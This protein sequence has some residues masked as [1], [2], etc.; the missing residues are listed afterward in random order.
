MFNGKEYIYEIY[1]A[2]SFS[3]AAK[4]LFIS[5]PALSAAVRKIENNLG[6]KIFNRST[7]PITLTETGKAYITAVKQIMAI[8]QNFKDQIDNI[9]NLET[10]YLNVGGANFFSSCMLPP[11]I[12][13]FK[14]SYQNI[15]IDI[16]ESDSIDIYHHALEKPI[17]LILDAGTY[18][19]NLFNA[20]YITTEN[21][22]LGIPADNPINKKYKKYQLTYADINS[23][24]HLNQQ[25]C[26]DL[27]TLA[28]EHFILLKPG[29]DMYS[30]S[31][32]I[33]QN[34]GFT[35]ADDTLFLNQLMTAYNLG[36]QG[37]GIVFV[38][39][40]LIKLASHQD[41]M[42]YY[43][44]DD[45]FAKRDIFLA[46]RKDAVMTMAMEKFIE[47]SKQLYSK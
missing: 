25:K 37:I 38:T 40:T 42:L 6:T 34:Q 43:R 15:T 5:Q 13:I 22:L 41:N 26:I 11:I 17:D 30:R 8:E 44:I 47:I 14:K 4:N 7:N 2:G 3:R 28:N 33:C 19:H 27:S 39:D 10:G 18:D 45:R 36:T 23:D 12:K 16:T 35:P 29:H 20:H 31:I 24:C 21:I 9:S 32:K 1:K 46:H